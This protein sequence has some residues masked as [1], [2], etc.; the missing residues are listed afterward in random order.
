MKRN[1]FIRGLLLTTL[2]ASTTVSTHA[3]DNKVISGDVN[4]ISQ[5]GTSDDRII[6]NANKLG[7]WVKFSLVYGDNNEIQ[8]GE[9][10]DR[11]TYNAIIGDSNGYT[12]GD[13]N[14]FKQERTISGSHISILGYGNGAEGDNISVVGTNNG[15][16][17]IRKGV[18]TEHKVKGNDI[19]ILGNSN[20][21][22]GDHT[23]VLGSETT[24]THAN[25]VAL[26]YLSTD[27]EA[28]NFDK[29]ELEGL[30]FTS[31]AG[32]GNATNGVVTVGSVGKE[33]QIINVAAGEIA[34][35]STDAING[36]QLYATNKILANVSKSVKDIFGGNAAITA[37][38]ELTFTNIG[39][40]GTTTIHD[41]IA[42]NST[43]IAKNTEAIQANTNSINTLQQQTNRL[44]NRISKVGA[45]AAALAALHPLDFNKDDKWSFSV[46]YGN[47]RDANAM[48]LGAFYRPNESTM[49]N[50]AGSMG[51]GENM[52]NAGV[53][54]KIGQSTTPSTKGDSVSNDV[55]TLKRIVQAQQEQLQLQ[56]EEIKKLKDLVNSK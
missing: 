19:G 28:T 15:Y 51:N 44:D 26:G 4:S 46:G 31:F 30:T 16:T 25:S 8:S 13:E 54:F 5:E 37:D 27:R 11:H 3:Y 48:A 22:N 21:V 50:I 12:Y 39:G 33:R 43:S 2:L 18:R 7:D 35:S 17:S 53:S 14:R 40:T 47:Y 29:L 52:V 56:Q 41:A 23:F 36:S 34:N 55:E 10:F 9:K 45:G 49:V 6:G 42:S 1:L 32:I 24:I 38:G 20:N